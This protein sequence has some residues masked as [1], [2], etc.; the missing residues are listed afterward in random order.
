MSFKNSCNTVLSKS[1]NIFSE[2]SDTWLHNKPQ[3]F[4]KTN[5]LRINN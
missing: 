3:G 5:S 4:L 2:K 1:K